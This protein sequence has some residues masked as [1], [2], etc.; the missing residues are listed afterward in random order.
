M[1]QLNEVIIMGLIMK[2]KKIEMRLSLYLVV[3]IFIYIAKRVTC[4]VFSELLALFEI[5]K[6]CIA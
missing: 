2:L 3:R 1:G 4:K 5:L 6:I